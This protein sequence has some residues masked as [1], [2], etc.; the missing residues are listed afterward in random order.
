[1]IV[2]LLVGVCVVKSF[3]IS[4]G[5]APCELQTFSIPLTKL[6]TFCVLDEWVGGL[7]CQASFCSNLKQQTNLFNI[8]TE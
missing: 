1:M 8:L 7:V 2:F 5:F 3:S 4:N 6:R